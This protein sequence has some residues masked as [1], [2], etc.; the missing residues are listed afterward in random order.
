[1]SHLLRELQRREARGQVISTA[2][3]GAGFM[4][5]GVV[6]QLSRMPGMRPALIVNR[7]T[8]AALAAYRLAGVD[9]REV[10]VSNDVRQH[11]RRKSAPARPTDKPATE[12]AAE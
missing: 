7:T 9:P 3:L 5:R 10:L 1:M 2:V 11:L 12:A 6:H 4:G 8:E